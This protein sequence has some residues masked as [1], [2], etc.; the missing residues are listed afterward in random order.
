MPEH[1]GSSDINTSFQ[2]EVLRGFALRQPFYFAAAAGTK[3]EAGEKMNK[4]KFKNFA[5]KSLKKW[6]FDKKMTWISIPIPK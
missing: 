3:A 5:K 4:Q 2:A 1:E 6:R